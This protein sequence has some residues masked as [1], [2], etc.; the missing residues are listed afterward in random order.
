MYI[1]EQQ[2]KLQ[3]SNVL[4]YFKARKVSKMVKNGKILRSTFKMTPQAELVVILFIQ[5]WYYRQVNLELKY[6]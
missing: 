4:V 3:N 5:F 1:M 6:I 2:K